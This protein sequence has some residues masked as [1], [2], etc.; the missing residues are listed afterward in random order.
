MKRF[1]Q[2]EIVAMKQQIKKTVRLLGVALV[3][4]GLIGMT[5]SLASARSP[6]DGFGSSPSPT[7][8]LGCKE[9][10]A[11]AMPAPKCNATTVTT[12]KVAGVNVTACHGAVACV[13]DGVVPSIDCKCK[14]KFGVLVVG[15]ACQC[16]IDI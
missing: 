2:K 1:F 13:P 9:G 4:F 11:G 3:L 10:A 14:P 15:A 12:I 7:A 8:V 16:Q 6:L 5:S